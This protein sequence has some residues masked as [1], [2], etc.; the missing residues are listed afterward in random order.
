VY[1]VSIAVLDNRCEFLSNRPSV[2]IFAMLSAMVRCSVEIC[3][4]INCRSFYGPQYS[5]KR[6]SAPC[7]Y[8]CHS[9]SL[10]DYHSII[11]VRALPV[12]M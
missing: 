8:T 1:C 3:V 2:C 4:P 9:F 7:E 5:T 12:V 6:R 10:H 11:A